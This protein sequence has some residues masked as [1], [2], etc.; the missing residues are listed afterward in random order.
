[1]AFA[2]CLTGNHGFAASLGEELARLQGVREE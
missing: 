1:L 2:A